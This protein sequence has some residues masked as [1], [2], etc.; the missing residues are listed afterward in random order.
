MIQSKEMHWWYPFENCVFISERPTNVS[1]DEVGRLHHSVRPAIEYSDGWK[2]YFWH[3]T[4]VPEDWIEKKN[5]VDPSTALTWQNTDQRTAL[6]EILGWDKVLEKLNPKIIDRDEDP[7]IGELIEVDL[8][9]S[10]GERFLRARCGTGK[11]ICLCVGKE[12]N[13]ALEANAAT[14]RLPVDIIR[15]KEVRT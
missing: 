3:G 10:P 6:A 4:N 9:D 15:K 12:Y 11:T 1:V 5:E 13:T 14:Y 2:F 8:P 7:Q